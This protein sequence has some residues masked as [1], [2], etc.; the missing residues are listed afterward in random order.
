VSTERTNFLR[1]I[2][3]DDLRTNKHD[4]RVAT[5]FPPEPNGYLHIGHSKSICLNFGLARDFNGQC[6]LRFDD[7]NPEKENIEYVESIQRD[8]KWLGFDWK[9]NLFH[10]SDYFERLYDLA[11]KLIHDGKAYVCE[12]TLEEVREYRGT[13]N[14]AGRHSPYRDRTPEENLALFER[15]RAGEFAEGACTLRAKIDMANPNMKMRDPMLYRI[16][17][18]THYR[19]GDTWCIYPMYDFTHCLSDAIEGITHSIC[20]L[21]FENNRELYDWV[22]EHTGIECQPKQF[23]FAR[24]NL[25]YTVM[26]KRKLLQLVNGGYVSGWDDPR[27]PTL[28]GLRRCGVPASAL[29]AFCERIGVAKNN[30]VIEV[31]LLE[32]TIREDLNPRVPRVLC[33]LEPLKVVIQNYPEGRT[34]WLDSPHFPHDVAKEGSRNVPFGR[35]IYIE[36]SDFEE[37]PPAGFKRLAPGRE[38]RLRHAYF[39]KCERVIKGPDGQ[40][41]ELHCS[42][43]PNT[44]GGQ[45]PDGRKVKG[46]IHWVSAEHGIPAEIRVYDRLF[47][48]EFPGTG[49]I[50][51]LTQLNPN[52]LVVHEGV[53]EPSVTEEGAETSFQFER[54]GYFCVD[55]KDSRP[56][57]LVFNRIVALRDSWTKKID[58]KA[59][60]AKKVENKA[61]AGKDSKRPAKTPRTI[62]LN[63]ERAQRYQKELKLAEKQVQV[64]A[65]SDDLGSFYDEACTHS[66]NPQ[67]LAAWMVNELQGALKERRI[68]DLTFGPADMAELIDLIDA[69]TINNTAA[70]EVLA[71][72][73]QSGNSPQL[74]VDER[75]L[76]QV[77]DSDA[78]EAAVQAVLDQNP[79]E[80]ERFK[81][82]EGRLMGFLIGQ[83]MRS[84]GGKANPGVV[85]QILKDKLSR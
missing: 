1:E 10:A 83:I 84:T 44:R 59:P 28:A 77:S 38:V 66:K 22:I 79:D 18:K 7:T 6:H 49:D 12:Q 82:G 60:P 17:H 21:E 52:S 72:M 31:A 63:K 71:E 64:L 33:V 54:Q 34:E 69:G 73:V 39:I 65:A 36:R 5:R 58:T 8:I 16:R 23:E 25:T 9:E 61:T 43:E 30:S 76:K 81:G 32:H 80:V 74:I 13:V 62:V 35:E 46:T 45:A 14:E 40:V 19:A 53:I 70:K 55:S 3:E 68:A 29:R 41:V 57:K 27:M 2:I 42:Y 26:S 56:E 47:S 4:G 11:A 78:I 20:T 15:M 51:F 50:D 24:M 85:Q 37:E 75:G 67:L 48:H